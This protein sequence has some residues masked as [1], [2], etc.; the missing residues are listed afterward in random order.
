MSQQHEQ[1]AYGSAIISACL[2]DPMSRSEN[3]SSSKYGL[4]L[5]TSV[6]VEELACAT[7]GARNGEG[8]LGVKGVMAVLIYGEGI[9]SGYFKVDGPA[10]ALPAV[11]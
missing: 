8:R 3:P 10:W 2:S 1:G 9:G 7:E 11:V 4:V 6:L 5:A